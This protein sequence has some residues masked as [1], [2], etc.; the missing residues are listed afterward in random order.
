M[1]RATWIT[2]IVTGVGIGSCSRILD[3][4]AGNIA[5]AGFILFFL[6]AVFVGVIGITQMREIINR[7]P[8]LLFPFSQGI[9][10]PQKEDFAKF[11]LPTWGRM[12]AC[13]LAT[14]ITVFTLKYF[15]L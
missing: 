2:S 4:S 12:L 11:Y 3:V 10:I 8:P 1:M 13:F 7:F 15:R 14:A 5:T 6:A 9:V